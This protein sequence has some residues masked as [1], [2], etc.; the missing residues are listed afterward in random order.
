MNGNTGNPFYSFSQIPS[1]ISGPTSTKRRNVPEFSTSTPMRRP[2]FQQKLSGLNNYA[3][4]V[5]ARDRQWDGIKTGFDRVRDSLFQIFRD[6][7]RDRDYL[8]ES[9]TGPGLPSGI[10]DPG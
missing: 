7:G 5:K 6:P 1:Q 8:P 4:W 10:R 9:G 3:F 2:A